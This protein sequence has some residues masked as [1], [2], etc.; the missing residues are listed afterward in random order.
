MDAVG[1][2]VDL[3]HQRIGVGGFQLCQL[4]PFQH[5]GGQVVALVSNTKVPLARRFA[6]LEQ[7]LAQLAAA[8]GPASPLAAQHALANARAEAAKLFTVGATEL[9]GLLVERQAAISASSCAPTAL[10]V[11]MTRTSWRVSDRMAW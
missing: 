1:L 8:E 5:A 11:N 3:V 2:R 9:D 6:A 7:A 4:A 10:S